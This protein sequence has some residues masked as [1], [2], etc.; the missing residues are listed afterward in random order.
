LGAAFTTESPLHF[1][2]SQALFADRFSGLSIRAAPPAE[3]SAASG[4]KLPP[5]S[6]VFTEFHPQKIKSPQKLG[7]G[8][9]RW[10]FFNMI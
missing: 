1:S 5:K 6:W 10:G 8:G 7:S 2:C 4:G 9:H 3:L